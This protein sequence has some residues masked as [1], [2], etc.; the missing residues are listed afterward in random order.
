MSAPFLEPADLVAMPLGVSWSTMGQAGSTK[1]SD[2]VNVA[3]L[4]VVCEF[5]T[6]E[7]NRE[8]NQSLPCQY[9]SED[10]YMPDHRASILSNG[11]GRLLCSYNPIV[12]VPFGAF[13][14][15]QVAYPKTWTVA[16]AGA[17]WPERRPLGVYGSSAPAGFG[18]GNNAI[19]IAGGLSWGYGGGLG[20]GGLEWWVNYLHGWPHGQLTANCAKSAATI[21]VDEVCGMLGAA[22]DILDGP[23]AE[24]VQC[25]SVSYPTPA[26]YSSTGNYWPGALVNDTSANTWQ[27]TIANGPGSPSGVQA[28]SNASTPYWSSVIVPVGPGTLTLAN[29]TQFAHTAPVLVTAMP[30]G[31]RQGTAL[32]AKA[33]ALQQ[34]LATLSITGDGRVVTIEETIMTAQKMAAA[35][36]RP[37]SRVY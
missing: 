14:A 21:Q 22:L 1:P 23:N 24:V 34:G 5:A 13:T 37:F 9:V 4:L 36:V 25:A 33:W 19:Q 29:P 12:S 27:C 31:V 18:G 32:Y 17:L 28:P 16:Q 2:P 7:V 10:W 20:R 3:A 6:S 26:T 11:N 15:A 35:A 8:C 30:R